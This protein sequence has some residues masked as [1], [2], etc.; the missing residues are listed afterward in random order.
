MIGSNGGCGYYRYSGAANAFYG[1]SSNGVSSIEYLSWFPKT[2][3][4]KEGSSLYCTDL[5][6]GILA[7]AVVALFGYALLPRT[8]PAMLYYLLIAWGFFYV[9]LIGQPSSVNYT[10]IAINSLGEVFVL[11]A[12]SHFVFRLAPAYTFAEWKQLCLRQRV[13]LWG[14]CYVVPYHLLLHLNFVAYVP[15]LNFDLGGYEEAETNAGTYIVLAVVVGFILFCAFVFLRQLYRLGIWQKYVVMYLLAIGW[16]LIS[17]TLFHS[18]DFHLHH[19]MLAALIIPF[20][21]FPTPLAAAAQSAALGA[22]IQ[23][24]G[25][26]GWSSYLDTIRT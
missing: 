12:A 24:Y 8:N 16:V 11:L 7:V 15:W 3:E 13:V 18:T 17:W 26:W 1:S 4:F 23:G 5:S 19:T 2:M 14:V 25:A 10:S 20:T 9:R 6:W 22:C 21:R